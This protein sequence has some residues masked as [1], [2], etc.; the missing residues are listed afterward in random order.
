M[1]LV[2]HNQFGNYLFDF[3]AYGEPRIA[4]GSGLFV[5]R[6][7]T[8]LHHHFAL[9]RSV[10]N[11]LFTD[12]DYR[13]EIFAKVVGRRHLTKLKE[14]KLALIGTQSATMIQIMDA[15]VFYEWDVVSG[16]YAGRLEI[17]PSPPHDSV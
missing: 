11:F 8:A 6:N 17:R 16:N 3:W 4:K 12:G 7:G 1:H 13:V 9:S 14:I 10:E 5:P 15:G 2:V